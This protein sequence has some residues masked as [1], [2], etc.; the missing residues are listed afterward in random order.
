MNGNGYVD[1]R[2]RLRRDGHGLESF[3]LNRGSFLLLF[4][5]FRD[6]L[7]SNVSSRNLFFFH[8]CARVHFMYA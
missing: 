7:S 4:V 1:W 6:S 8:L 2:R 3:W 5:D